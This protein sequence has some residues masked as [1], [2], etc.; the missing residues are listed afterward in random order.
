MFAFF[1]FGVLNFTTSPE[2]LNFT[3][4]LSLET[5]YRPLKVCRGW[6]I[7]LDLSVGD[8]L[9][10]ESQFLLGTPIVTVLLLLLLR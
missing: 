5:F 10:T 2:I 9:Q 3:V 8:S 6:G 1:L 4:L 7:G